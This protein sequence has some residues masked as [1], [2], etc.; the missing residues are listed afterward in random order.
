MRP[1]AHALFIYWIMA[2]KWMKTTGISHSSP[3]SHAAS[4]PSADF[5]GLQ[6]FGSVATGSKKNYVEETHRLGWLQAAK[7]YLDITWH[8]IHRMITSTRVLHHD[9]SFFYENALYCI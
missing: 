6:K 2:Q 4:N 1:Q 8:K 7:R 9:A 5:L 3:S